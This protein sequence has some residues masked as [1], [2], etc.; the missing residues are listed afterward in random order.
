MRPAH[1]G[2]DG[3]VEKQRMPGPALPGAA[4]LHLRCSEQR[5]RARFRPRMVLMVNAGLEEHFRK[6]SLVSDHLLAHQ[7]S[8]QGRDLCLNHPSRTSGRDQ[9]VFEPYLSAALVAHHA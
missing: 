2:V 9:W 4:A 8:N 6:N 5:L 1:P 7:P 3:G